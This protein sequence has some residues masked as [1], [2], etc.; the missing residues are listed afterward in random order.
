MIIITCLIICTFL[1]AW[2]NG[3][4]DNFKGVATLYG[5]D[6]VSYKQALFI[7]TATTLL[8]S[9]CSIFL[10]GEL[11][12]AF[13]GKGI[14]PASF[15]G[16]PS[17]L[18][19]VAA[20]SAGTVFL[21]TFTGFPVSTTHSLIGGLC[22]AALVGFPADINWS[23]LGGKLMLP[24]ML[25]PFLAIIGAAFFYML[26]KKCRQLLH[27][28]KSYCICIGE[29]CETITAQT[30]QNA[31]AIFQQ[32][33]PSV[34]ISDEAQCQERYHGHALGIKCETLLD[35]LHI[36]SAC[37]VSFARGLNDTPKIL[38]LLVA[39]S[40]FDI[41][42][43]WGLAAVAI[44]MAIG[45]L[46]NARRVAETLGKRITSMNRGQ[47]L[48]ANLMT[49]ILVTCASR[50]GVPVSTTHVSV[51]ALFGIG[52]VG[53][54]AHKKVIGHVLLSWVLTLPIAAFISAACY[55]CIR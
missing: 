16:D 24:L 22:G 15:V 25:S 4:N 14:V 2:A 35:A 6:T 32:Y 3:A 12:K 42:P 54:G 48:T 43:R 26:F 30:K 44:V 13:S 45:G 34:M 47:G 27:I 36:M 31:L 1:V 20:G 38:G 19:A 5:S 50:F 49:G 51:G 23:I 7:A 9:L 29:T 11:V 55:L 39:L 18:L 21:A 37:L 46:V 40:V 8:G 28:D 41:D 52:A 17:L 33:H 53:G 10:A